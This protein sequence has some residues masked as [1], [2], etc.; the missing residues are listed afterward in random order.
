MS[1]FCPGLNIQGKANPILHPEPTTET[2]AKRVTLTI[3]WRQGM[4]DMP[5][6]HQETT[7]TSLFQD[8][9]QL[10]EVDQLNRVADPEVPEYS[11]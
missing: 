11:G 4:A 6:E 2:M 8:L 3:D 1:A 5:P 7:T 10:D 9:S